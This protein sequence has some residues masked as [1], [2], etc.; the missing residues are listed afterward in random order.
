MNDA[1]RRL[2]LSL[3]SSLSLSARIGRRSAIVVVHP[4]PFSSSLLSIRRW[5][6]CESIEIDDVMW[7]I[8]ST[9][10]KTKNVHRN[11]NRNRVNRI[12]SCWWLNRLRQRSICLVQAYLIRRLTRENSVDKIFHN[13]L[14]TL[15]EA[16]QRRGTTVIDRSELTR[17]ISAILSAQTRA[18][19]ILRTNALIRISSCSCAHRYSLLPSPPFWLSTKTLLF[20]Y[21]DRKI[22][23]SLNTH[24]RTMRRR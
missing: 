12:E 2:S 23:P 7:V 1:R 13:C 18:K 19:V 15:N 8:I 14:S 11:R 24:K 22:N 10:G 9:W 3:R 16:H 20:V 17:D 6:P 4:S 21:P 5:C